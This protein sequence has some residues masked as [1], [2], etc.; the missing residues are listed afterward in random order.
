MSDSKAWEMHT[1]KDNRVPVSVNDIQPA[2]S[3][4][5]PF[6]KPAVTLYR[7]LL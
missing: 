2:K 1:D 3:F 6:P 5:F 7:N 4:R